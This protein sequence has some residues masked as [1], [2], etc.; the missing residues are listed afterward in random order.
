MA[1]SEYFGIQPTD[2]RNVESRYI[3]T[4]L[5][6]QTTYAAV[7][8]I[9]YLDVYVNGSWK[10]PRTAYT[11]TDGANVIL[12]VA[13]TIGDI[14]AIIC[15]RQVQYIRGIETVISNTFFTA[16]AGQTSFPMTYTPG[17]VSNVDRNGVS[18][19]YTASDGSNV[20]LGAAANAGDVVRITSYGSFSVANAVA[21]SGD[22]MVGPLT[23]S[24]N[25]T[26]PLQAVPKQQLDSAV[27]A[28]TAA[29]TAAA[30]A[31]SVQKSGDTMSGALNEAA[32]TTIA[33]ASSVAIGAA[34]SNSVTV[35]GNA[36]ITSFD[37]IAAGAIRR[38]VF[39]GTPIL[40][41]NATTMILPTQA[42][43]AVNAGDT[44]TFVSNGAGSWTCTSYTRANGSA[45]S[46]PSGSVYYT[47]TTFGGF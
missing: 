45:L 32:P 39:T 25:A 43:I 44:A 23:L 35:T 15:R 13:S 26:Q 37:T 7:Y 10:D 11:A 20:V 38:L 36:T 42:S 4:A 30:V 1:E 6:G 5:A 27:S 12:S 24:G 34:S 33:S 3:Y 16:T 8:D 41:Y 22:T 31:S 14:V 28:A 46:A 19:P 21:K 9:G 2:T 29:G 17:A 47:Y 18:V 40:L